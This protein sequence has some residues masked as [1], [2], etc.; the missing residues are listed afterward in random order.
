MKFISAHK[1]M[2]VVS[3]VVAVVLATGG[4]AY[5]YFTSTGHNASRLPSDTYNSSR[6]CLRNNDRTTLRCQWVVTPL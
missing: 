5:A 4:A 1:R 2:A 6:Q 3:L